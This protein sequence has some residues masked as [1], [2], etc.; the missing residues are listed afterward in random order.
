[1]SLLMD[2]LKR[3]ETSKQEAAR[4][5]S[6]KDPAAADLLGLEPLAPPAPRAQNSPLPD[7][8]AHI[9]AVDAELASSAIRPGQAQPKPATS[10]QKSAQAD[11]EAVRNAFAAKQ[12]DAPP[13]RQPLWIAL[14]ILG[15]AGLGIGGYV[16]YQVLNIGN[17]SLRPSAPSPA[18]SVAVNQG[19][20]PAPAVPVVLPPSVPSTAA[21]APETS[22]FTSPPPAPA[23]PART[24]PTSE[25]ESPPAET[26]RLTRSRPE[27]DNNQLRGYANI[28]RN[29]LE[30]ARRDYEQ[31]LQRDPNNTD[32]LLALAAIAQ[33]QGRPGDAERLYQRALVAN[34]SDPAVQAATLNGANAGADPQNTESRLKSLLAAQPES[35]QLNFALG[36][37]YARQQRWAEAQQVYFNAVAA[38]GDNPDY[39]FNLAI[40]LDHIRQ[41]K[42][43]A[44]HYRLALEA[45]DKRP[46]AFEREPVR[47]RLSELQP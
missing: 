24:M 19:A 43:A 17:N 12:V 26:I 25:P 30:L 34:P 22:L 46:A 7:L 23:R 18:P 44:Q 3:A 15:V 21:I 10:Q 28:Q 38:D 35:A 40:S 39:L 32:A 5:L 36:N 29:E 4:S 2:A 11:R 1:M 13:S 20:T 8:A 9:D 42:L 33:R 16:A 14:G 6:G 27:V 47:K 41:G 45:A 31:A 37:L